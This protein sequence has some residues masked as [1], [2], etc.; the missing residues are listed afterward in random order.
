MAF[1]G[2]TKLPAVPHIYSKET[3]SLPY[4]AEEMCCLHKYRRPYRS[5]IGSISLSIRVSAL[6]TAGGNILRRNIALK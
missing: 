1:T 6:T 5:S 4:T 2:Q 3:V